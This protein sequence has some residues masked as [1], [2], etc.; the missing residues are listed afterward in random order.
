MD[1]FVRPNDL[2]GKA[3]QCRCEVGGLR[4]AEIKRLNNT[5]LLEHGGNIVRAS[6]A[7]F[8]QCAQSALCIM[9]QQH[10]AQIEQDT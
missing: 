4:V 2:S 7:G 3:A 10:I 1:R 5:G 9:K 6:V 8:A